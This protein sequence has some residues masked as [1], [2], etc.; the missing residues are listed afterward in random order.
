M[1]QI[2]S[3]KNTFKYILAAFI[4]VT[5]STFS[6]LMDTQRV[7]AATECD[8]EFYSLNDILFYDECAISTASCTT[9]T[10]TSVFKNTNYAGSEILST[11][12]LEAIE[13]NRSFYEKSASTEKIPWQII[14]SIHI[15]ETGLKRS[16]PSNGYGPYQITP[17]SYPIKAAYSDA[18]F[19]DA[20]DKAAAIIKAKSG[21]RDLTDP[22]NIKYTLFAYNGVASVYV[23]QGKSIGFTDAEAANGEGSPYVM[24]RFDEKRDSTVEPT[25]SN[26]T[27]GQIKIDHGPIAYPT[28]TDPGAFVYYT[29][30]TNGSL[31]GS[32]SKA[33]NGDPNSLQASF[34]AYMNANGETYAPFSYRLG[35]NGCTTLSSWYIGEYTSLTYGRGNGEA[36]VRNLISANSD[37]GLVAS[38]TPVA[39]AIFSVAGGS[40]AWG[41]SGIPAGHVGVV[42]SV[43]EQ[44]Q[45]ATVVHTGSTKAGAPEKAWVSEFK[46]P[47]SGVTFVNVGEYVK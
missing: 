12:Q 23:N 37:K 44:T 21:G 16:G 14:A 11:A 19:Q 39:P 17:A 43:N 13:S 47:S 5:A 36:V 29:A 32:G 6:P 45:T 3:S 27:W 40:K 2:Q 34:T 18:E 10:S 9:S 24:N 8:E 41:A 42:V 35:F 4:L 20:T 38:D 46:Y 1:K 28:N 7:S 26:R 15:R 25:K 22:N 33:I 30:L 31:C